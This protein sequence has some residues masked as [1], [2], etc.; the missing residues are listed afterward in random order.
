MATIK[1]LKTCDVVQAL[2]NSATIAQAC[3]HLGISKNTLYKYTASEEVQQLVNEVVAKAYS[4][5][6]NKLAVKHGE[7]LQDIDLI[8]HDTNNSVTVRLDALKFL[9][10]HIVQVRQLTT[11]EQRLTALEKGLTALEKG[12]VL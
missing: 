6:T 12:S 8:A 4:N 9:C 1:Q 3:K 5:L 2:V 11:I 7:Y 10:S